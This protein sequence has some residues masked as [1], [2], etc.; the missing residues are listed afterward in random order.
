MPF[1][2]SETIEL[3]E[4]LVGSYLHKVHLHNWLESNKHAS[5]FG[6][7]SIYIKVERLVCLLDRSD[8]E[9]GQNF[10]AAQGLNWSISLVVQFGGSCILRSGTLISRRRFIEQTSL[11]AVSAVLANCAFAGIGGA[12]EDALTP[13]PKLLE[14]ANTTV[15]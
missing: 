15:S 12:N 3:G 1:V 4:E 13:D 8:F 6:Q 11:M 10:C 14:R 9:P 2:C 7:R 5:S